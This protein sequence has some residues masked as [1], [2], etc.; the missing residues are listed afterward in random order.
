MRRR[1]RGRHLGADVA[2]ADQHHALGL[3]R[4]RPGSRPSWRTRAGSGSRR[5][6]QPSARSRRTL[7]PVA[8]SALSNPHR[9]LRGE[10]GH[11]LAGVELHHAGAREQL[12]VLLVP[13]LVR[14]VEHVLARPPR[15]AGSPWT[16]AGGCRA[17]RA[18]G[19]P[20][21]CEPSAPSSRS[22]RAQLAGGEAASDQQVVDGAVG[23]R[24]GRGRHAAREALG[25]ALLDAHVEHEQHL[26]AGLDHASRRWGR[27]RRRRAGSRSRASP[28]A[29]RGP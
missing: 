8:T 9:L 5:A 7:A 28:R 14:A 27:S 3:A 18:R 17:G 22:Q 19:R 16:A 24:S 25:D 10:R 26:V 12:D 23:H 1:E 2:A 4:P 20:A 13:P 15:R 11:A 6:R 21:G 29:G